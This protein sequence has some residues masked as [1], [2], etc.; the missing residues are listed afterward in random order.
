MI[1][2]GYI[3]YN[4]HWKKDKSLLPEK[5]KKLN[6]YRNSLYKMGLIGAYPDSGIGFGNVSIR[7]TDNPLNFII[8]GTKTGQLEELGPMHYTMVEAYDIQANT[9]FCRGP[10]KASSEALTHAMIY[11]LG[12]GLYDAIIHVH[13]LEMWKRLL[14]VVP[15]TG[16][17][18]S[19]GTPEMAFEVKRLFQEG[20]LEEQKILAMAGHYEGIITFGKSLEQA[21][22]VLEC[23][24]SQKTR[25]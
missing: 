9:V 3:K 7:D 10:I 11:Q 16:D 12:G 24:H 19:Y 6:E 18:I 1:D 25:T 8:T 20:K 2:E 13:S 22:E 21:F 15:T 5:W 23:F 14:N 4:C 17:T